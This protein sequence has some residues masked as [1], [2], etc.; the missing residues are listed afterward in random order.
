MKN[1]FK[2]I[3]MASLV[4]AGSA[5]LASCSKDSEVESII[6]EVES[7]VGAEEQPEGYF[8]ATFTSGLYSSISRTAIDGLSS[9]VQSLRYIIYKKDQNGVYQY[10][11][12]AENDKY[13]FGE[14]GTITEPMKWPY[15]PLSVK[16]ENGEYKVVFLGNMNE[17][18][19]VNG[20]NKND[21]IVTN[22]KGKYSDARINL[23][24]VK[25]FY[26]EAVS[27]GGEGKTSNFFYW[28]TV[29]VSTSNP[30]AEVLLQR[31][32]SKFE[33]CKETLSSED[34]ESARVAILNSIT[35]NVVEYLKSEYGITNLVGGEIG[36]IT[37]GVFKTFYIDKLEEM[38]LTPIVN[39]LANSLDETKLIPLVTKQIDGILKMNEEQG[40]LDLNALLNPWGTAADYAIVEFNKFPKAV[41]FDNKAVEFFEA[42]GDDIPRF[43]YT[44]SCQTDDAGPKNYL[45]IYG[46]GGEWDIKRIDATDD[47]HALIS[48]VLIDETVDGWLLPGSLHDADANLKHTFGSNKPYNS[49][50]SA[51]ALNVYPKD[52]SDDPLEENLKIKIDLNSVLNIEEILNGAIEEAGKKDAIDFRDEIENLK[53]ADTIGKVVVGLLDTLVGGILDLVDYLFGKTVSGVLDDIVYPALVQLNLGGKD[54]LVKALINA[55]APEG[56]IEIELPLNVTLLNTDNLEV[57]GGWTQVYEGELSEMQ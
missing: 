18:Q 45:R 28:D 19:F 12:K 14:D 16:L 46:L 20:E 5:Y 3:F 7:G 38:L 55:L 24:T 31:I 52:K 37:E 33:M 53:N 50:Y 56:G 36:K 1:I 47:K 44:M 17:R 8:T 35:D 34:K 49:V 23:P 27:D 9:R 43:A 11:T 51:L 21:S 32:V 15:T 26:E 54:G 42:S 39:A 6:D 2:N 41:S 4:V 25:G 13:L 30:N 29:E 40:L 10:Y 22:Y 57:S 48:G